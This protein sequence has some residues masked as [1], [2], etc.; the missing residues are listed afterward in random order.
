MDELNRRQFTQAAIGSLLAVSCLESLWHGKLFADDAKKVDTRWL[1]ELDELCRQV[2]DQRLHQVAWQSQVEAL[3]KRVDLPELLKQVDFE[4]L[5][6]GAS[7]PQHGARSLRFPLPHP[8]GADGKFV[9][10]RQ[11]FAVKKGASIIPHG[12]NNMATAFLILKGEFRGRHYDRVEDLA[13]H[14]LIRPTLDRTFAAGDGSTVSDYKDNVHWFKSASDAGF[15]F[16]I[17]VYHVTPGTAFGPG[18]VYLNPEGKR[19]ADGLIRAPLIGY[20]EANRL[21][22]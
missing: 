3:L 8:D 18:R 11:I 12:H 13:E 9:F 15:V 21:F 1:A 5:A 22:G 7:P 17:H 16:N 2:R 14:M 10:G 6:A 20:D 4:R 19:L